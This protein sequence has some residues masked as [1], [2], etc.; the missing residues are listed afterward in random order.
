MAARKQDVPPRVKGILAEKAKVGVL[1]RQGPHEWFQLILWNT[2][3]D[4]I[5]RGQWV[6]HDVHLCDVSPDGKLVVY[7]AHNWRRSKH[8]AWVGVS[9]PPFFSVLVS[10]PATAGPG[11]GGGVFKDNRELLLGGCLGPAESARKKIPLRASTGSLFDSWPKDWEGMKQYQWLGGDVVRLYRDHWNSLSEGPGAWWEREAAKGAWALR[12][13]RVTGESPFDGKLRALSGH[14]YAI[15]FDSKTQPMEG[16]EWADIDQRQRLV[17]TRAGKLFA[18]KVT[19]REGIVAEVEL[20]DFNGDKP[21]RIA[22]PP[23]ASQ[24][25]G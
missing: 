3:T 11:T 24:W 6:H 25:P 12:M 17:F 15:H 13:R 14:E 5:T 23:W 7:F 2:E 1:I 16:V 9:R 10:W 4:E 20:A 8:A 18:A 22:P 21:E 19:G